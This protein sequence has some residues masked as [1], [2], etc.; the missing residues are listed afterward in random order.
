MNQMGSMDKMLSMIPGMN[1]AK[2]PKDMMQKQEGKMKRWKAAI[3]S[4]TLQEIENPEVLE[5]Q[6]KRMG[7][8]AKG[9]GATT[10]EIRELLKQYSLL[11]DMMKMQQ[12]GN[13]DM[14]QG[15]DK[16]MMQK[17]AKKMRGKIKL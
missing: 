1:T 15:I 12:S 17:M 6:T 5:K 14:S 13:M 2:I 9:S 3:N 11:K 7:R 16:K 8:I 10:T 4:M